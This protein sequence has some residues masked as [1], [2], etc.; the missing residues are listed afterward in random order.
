MKVPQ[1]RIT[2]TLLEIIRFRDKKEELV[3]DSFAIANKL[4]V[5]ECR[6]RKSFSILR[7]QLIMFLPLRKTGH[8]GLYVLYE[9]TNPKHQEM[10]KKNLNMNIK[11][12]KTIYF[13]DVVKYLPIVKDVKLIN[14]IGQMYF[15]LGGEKL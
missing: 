8:K 13:N 6:V 14:E 9:E 12:I 1:E 5:A 7:G 11:Q 15:A 3:L 4:N 2:N 10:L